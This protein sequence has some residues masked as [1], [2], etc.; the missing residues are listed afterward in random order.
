M[1]VSMTALCDDVSA[2]TAVLR[3]ILAGLSEDDWHRATSRTSASAPAP[4]ATP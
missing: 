3:K 1:P 4:T 2:E